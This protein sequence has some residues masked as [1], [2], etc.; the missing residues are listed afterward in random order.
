MKKIVLFS[1][2]CVALSVIAFYSCEKTTVNQIPDENTHVET[3]YKTLNEKL[4]EYNATFNVQPDQTRARFWKGFWKVIKADALGALGGLSGGAKG[5]VI[6]CI[7]GSG[8]AA[9]TELWPDEKTSE[10]GNSNTE[11]TT[12]PE[13]GFYGYDEYGHALYYAVEETGALEEAVD[14]SNL[15]NMINRAGEIHNLFLNA[16]YL[17]LDSIFASKLSNTRSGDIHTIDETMLITNIVSDKFEEMGINISNSEKEDIALNV[18]EI[19]CLLFQSDNNLLEEYFT[20]KGL[21]EEYNI[22][23]SYIDNLDSSIN[24][25]ELLMQ[26]TSGYLNIILDSTI[27]RERIDLIFSSIMVAANSSLYWNNFTK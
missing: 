17:Q 2:L 5:V 9:I 25:R 12:P 4:A 14:G 23:I 11:P 8:K 15:E 13:N 16:I 26:Y 20:Q 3:A 24:N 21:K 10:G 18:D 19:N 22:V 27:P 1:T 6:G 7:V